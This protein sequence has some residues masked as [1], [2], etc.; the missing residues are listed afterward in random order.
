[1]L[2]VTCSESKRLAIVFSNFFL[3]NTPHYSGTATFM[4]KKTID[5]GRVLIL[6]MYKGSSHKHNAHDQ[7]IY[8][9]SECKL[10]Q[11]TRKPHTEYTKK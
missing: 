9:Q 7:T 4:P 10:N 8:V 1:M 3:H 2:I 6:T 11:C 5:E